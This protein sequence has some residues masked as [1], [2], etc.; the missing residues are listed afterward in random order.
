MR[1]DDDRL[2]ELLD[3]DQERLVATA[4]PYGFELRQPRKRPLEEYG[5]RAFEGADTV[6]T[7]LSGEIDGARVELFE[8]DWVQTGS[9][10]SVQRGRRTI[11]LVKHPSIDGEARCTWKFVQSAPG[12][13]LL[14]VFQL[15]M[16]AMLFWLVIP[17]WI[18]QYLRGE[19]PFP[20]DHDVGDPDFRRRFKVASASTELARRAL[21]E[22]LRRVVLDAELKGPLEV[23]PG[24]VAL[25]MRYSELD[26]IELERAIALTRRVVHAYAPPGDRPNAA[27]RVASEVAPHPARATDDQEDEEDARTRRA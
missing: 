22:A 1:G 10:G 4:A 9:K 13:A 11:A 25:S 12:R 5:L 20:K 16:L 19:D 14:F 8:Y 7:R 23:R 18:V 17:I 6:L 15:A 3:E 2:G 21:P 27:Y 24:L 26:P